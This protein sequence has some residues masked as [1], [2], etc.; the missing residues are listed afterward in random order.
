MLIE[1]VLH[2]IPYPLFIGD[3]VINVSLLLTTG[4]FEITE[5]GKVKCSG[6]ITAANGDDDVITKQPISQGETMEED[7]WFR[8]LKNEDI[9][10]ELRLRGYEYGGLF[11]G[12]TSAKATGQ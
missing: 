9:Y 1:V 7:D 2:S 4:A 12:I 10:K 3:T 11:K 6:K 5:G 8:D